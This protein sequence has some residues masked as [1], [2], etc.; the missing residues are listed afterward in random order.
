MD[1]KDPADDTVHT[2]EHLRE[3]YRKRRIAINSKDGIKTLVSKLR[4]NDRGQGE[5]I[6][7]PGQDN[8]LEIEV[9]SERFE[10]SKV[11]K[12]ILESLQSSEEVIGE[13]GEKNWTF[14]QK[15]ELLYPEREIMR[16]RLE[17]ERQREREREEMEIRRE[18]RQRVIRLEEREYEREQDKNILQHTLNKQENQGSIRFIRMREM[19]EKEDIDGY[20]RIF[21]MTAKTQII[22]VE[23]WLASLIPRLTEKAKEVYLQIPGAEA[24]DFYKSKER[25]LKAYQRTA[26]YYRYR[27]RHSEKGSDE[28]FVQWAHRTR[29]YLDR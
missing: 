29:R 19:R 25:I 10:E 2:L 1:T 20:F 8:G 28:D 5:E 24:Q 26:D 13:K 23:E 4:V 6:I 17:M 11:D 3:E 27:F 15:F 16:E 9:D 12:E 7:Y 18:E 21:E 22:P 14:Q